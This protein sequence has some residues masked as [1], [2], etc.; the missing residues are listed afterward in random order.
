M[1]DSTLADALWAIDPAKLPYSEWVNVGMALKSVGASLSLWCDWSASDPRYK[2]GEMQAKW[3]SFQSNGVGSG[4]IIHLA[5]MF[6]WSYATSGRVLDWN[7]TLTVKPDPTF[8]NEAEKITIKQ[9]GA[10]WDPIEEIIRYLTTLFRPDDK[11]GY[12][13]DCY[14]S[15]DGK[16][17]PYGGHFKRTRDELINALKKHGDIPSVL[18]SYNTDAGGWINFNPTDGEGRKKEN[19]TA[20]R[21][22]LVESDSTPIETQIHIMHELKLPVAILVA[23]GGKS[24]HAIVHIDALTLEEYKAR[25]TDLFQICEE[26]GISIDQNNKNPGRLSRMPGL[27]R[28]DQ[29]QFIIPYEAETHSWQEWHDGQVVEQMD[30]PPI[31]SVS[32]F[33]GVDTPTLAPELISG[34]LREGH[35]MLI[36]GPSKA[37]KSFALIELSIAIGT[38]GEWFGWKCSEGQV[39]YLNFELD[40]RSC[41]NR[42]NA[43]A[44]ALKIS[45]KE[46]CR[47]VHVMNLRGY[48]MSLDKFVPYLVGITRNTHY[49][50]VI[51]DP[52]YKVMTGDENSAGDMAHFCNYFDMVC[53]EMGCAT[54]Y[55]HH[56]S[57][58][59]QS[60]KA[61]MDRGS[62]SGVFARDPDAIIDLL[63]LRVPQSFQNFITGGDYPSE[64][65][66]LGVT[67][68]Q[69]AT[70]WKVSCVLRE[71]ATPPD[72][73]LWFAYPLHVV[74]MYNLASCTPYDERPSDSEARA[75]N[76][77]KGDQN[78]LRMIMA[79]RD[80]A[81][82][83]FFPNNTPIHITQIMANSGVGVGQQRALDYFR[84][85]NEENGV[86]FVIN[87]AQISMA[88]SRNSA[89]LPVPK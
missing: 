50:A 37:G 7:D 8:F 25:V 81:N 58:G 45:P 34:I 57:K 9:P 43:V 83:G 60:G 49:K 17:K 89:E 65:D 30:L 44:Q 85:F 79:Y 6:G 73:K 18:G 12:T 23:S 5:E 75:A 63:R 27:I 70:A 56:H 69:D 52:L 88:E 13:F 68:T 46:A 53:R 32:D 28:G 82:S 20:F 66:S 26:A 19:I 86:W 38:G 39:L 21:Y 54:I 41:F 33:V 55:C 31:Q 4:T 61:V 67:L 14:T 3:D 35:K 59:S 47:N 40:E 80:M 71:F 78:R 22:A 84:E 76:E 29:K 51:F 87:R 74:D 16:F 1:I 24:A 77:A 48:N 2:A 15:E 72:V 62:G 64:L 10:N 11:V 42:F 36:T